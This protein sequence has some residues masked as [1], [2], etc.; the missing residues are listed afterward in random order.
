MVLHGMEVYLMRLVLVNQIIKKMKEAIWTPRFIF[1]KQ[2]I[3]CKNVALV[4]YDDPSSYVNKNYSFQFSIEEISA[5]TSE[6]TE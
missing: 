5:V 1:H 4:A 6:N 3:T 2:R